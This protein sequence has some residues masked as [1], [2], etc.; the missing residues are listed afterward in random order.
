M[1]VAVIVFSLSLLGLG[2][3]WPAPVVVPS[4]ELFGRLWLGGAHSG[5]AGEHGG[6]DVVVARTAA[7]VALKIGANHLFAHP[8]ATP[9]HDIDG[10]HDHAGRAEAALQAMMLAEG[11]LHGVQLAALGQ[12]F[13]AQDLGAIA[14]RRERGTRFDRP[15]I[16]M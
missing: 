13:D 14:G 15:T 2:A 16:D 6:D 5:G 1:P 12:A 10:S 11:L 8:A 3:A 9:L 4:S 7:D